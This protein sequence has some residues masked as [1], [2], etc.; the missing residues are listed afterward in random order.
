M[1]HPPDGLKA[2]ERHFSASKGVVFG[3]VEETP[4]Q[5]CPRPCGKKIRPRPGGR[6]ARDGMGIREKEELF[7]DCSAHFSSL[8]WRTGVGTDFKEVSP[9]RLSRRGPILGSNPGPAAGRAI[10]RNQSLPQT[11]AHPLQ[12]GRGKDTPVCALG[13][14]GGAGLGWDHRSQSLLGLSGSS[15]QCL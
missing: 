7:W 15:R 6:R 13:S 12:H 8:E 5:V 10:E 3:E 2:L 14:A 1:G 9:S 4:S 11:Q